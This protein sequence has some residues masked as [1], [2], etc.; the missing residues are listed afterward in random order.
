MMTKDTLHNRFV[1]FKP[2]GLFGN[3]MFQIATT[4]GYAKKHGID[5]KLPKWISSDGFDLSQIFKGPFGTANESEAVEYT[6]YDMHYTEIPTIN[7]NIKLHGYFQNEKYFKDAEEDLREIFKPHEEISYVEDICSIHVRRGDYLKYPLIHTNISMDYYRNAIEMMKSKGYQKFMIFSDD[8]EWCKQNF[9]G[10]EYSFSEGQKNY[11]DLI[12]MSSC[13]SHI[14]ANSSFSWWGAWLGCNPDKI[15]IAPS[16]WFG[17][18]G[19]S[20][21]EI[22]PTNWI[23]L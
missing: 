3:Q 15:V 14:I 7:K 5:Y 1:T 8:I 17:P 13:G 11:Q 12:K 10:E 6:Y 16:N 18:K 9:I 23:K 20:N 22:I 4:V 19:P 2:L 21:Y